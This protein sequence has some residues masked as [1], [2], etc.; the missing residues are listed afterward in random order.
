MCLS[1]ITTEILAFIQTQ[2]TL[3][4]KNT[5][6][7]LK[8]A[9]KLTENIL[10]LQQTNYILK[11]KVVCLVPLFK[12]EPREHILDFRGRGAGQ[13]IYGLICTCVWY[14]VTYI[15]NLV[16][17]AFITTEFSA[18][19]QTQIALFHKNTELRLNTAFKLIE[20]RLLLKQN[21]FIFKQNVLYSILMLNIELRGY[22]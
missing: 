16:S 5:E 9:L 12:I 6:L 14:T 17:L 22:I 19:I 11:Q 7:R 4:Y 10:I 3:F 21:Y 18:F 15:R 8:T 13:L 2:N 20:N 1:S